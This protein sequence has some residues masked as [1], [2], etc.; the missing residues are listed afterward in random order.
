MKFDLWTWAFQ[1]INFVVLLL[2]L[3]RILYRPVREIMEKRRALAARTLEEAER[4]R[5]EAQQLQ[6]QN[7]LEQK[8]LQE[9]RGKMLEE[10]KTEVAEARQKL[11][12]ETDRETQRHIDK[13]RA[14]F[15]AEKT[16]QTVAIKEL[17]MDTVLLF[18]TNICRDIADKNLHRALYRRLLDE[19]EQ[20]AAELHS[21]PGTDELLKV[22]VTSAYPLRPEDERPLQE[23]LKAGGKRRVSLHTTLDSELLAGVKIKAGDISYDASLQGQLHAFKLRL[24][25]GPDA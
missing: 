16:R 6:A 23:A 10:M 9:Q 19:L 15:E 18:A 20:L 2:I 17:A 1:I 24:K 3:K 25:E 8:R 21:P 4:T 12:A 14:L 5:S 22:E 13:E 7:Q 11:L